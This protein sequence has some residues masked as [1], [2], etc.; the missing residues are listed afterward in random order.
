M[1]NQDSQKGARD[2]L[3]AG[4]LFHTDREMNGSLA[5]P[6]TIGFRGLDLVMTINPIL[7][8]LYYETPEGMLAAIRQMCY[9]VLFGHIVEYDWAFKDEESAKVM[10]VAMEAEVN[11]YV[12]E[13]PDTVVTLKWVKHIIENRLILPKAGTLYYYNELKAVKNDSKK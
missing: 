11:Q 12:D 8:Y 13:L 5:K 4:I 10:S 6:I 7:F 9:H 3:F 1:N 2:V